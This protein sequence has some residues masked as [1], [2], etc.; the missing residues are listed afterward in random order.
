MSPAVVSAPDHTEKR[1][2]FDHTILPAAGSHA[3]K[4]PMPPWLPGVGYMVKVAPTYGWPAVYSIWNGSYVMQTWLVGTNTRPDFGSKLD[5]C[6]SLE[7]SAAGQMSFTSTSGP[8][9]PGEYFASTTGR[10]VFISTLVAQLTC[11]SYFSATNS[12][13]V[14][15]FIV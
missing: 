2:G 5:G 12:S 11:G 4:L 7:P 13:P 6:S 10:P 8:V 3:M 1:S 15:R 14:T 9:V